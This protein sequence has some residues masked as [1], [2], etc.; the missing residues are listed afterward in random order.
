[1]R[2]RGN[3]A[4]LRSRAPEFATVRLGIGRGLVKSGGNGCE[5]KRAL[6][7]LFR[8]LASR[9][10][11]AINA[12]ARARPRNIAGAYRDNRWWNTAI[13]TL[14]KDIWYLRG[15]RA[16]PRRDTRAHTRIRTY[17]GACARTGYIACVSTRAMT[18]ATATTTTASATLY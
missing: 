9:M 6:G 5:Q 14:P 4:L 11:R 18:T 1:M 2:R 12:N 17:L 16:E 7:N 3:C 13:L 10:S 15:G 8:E